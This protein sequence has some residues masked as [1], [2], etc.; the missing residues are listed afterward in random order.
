MCGGGAVRCRG[1]GGLCGP[2]LRNP[3]PLRDQRGQAAPLIVSQAH[4]A[5]A[6]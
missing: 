1:R 2:M 3:F 6:R 4:L 5:V